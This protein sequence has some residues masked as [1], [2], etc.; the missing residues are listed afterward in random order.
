VSERN[1]F[2]EGMERTN[3]AVVAYFKVSFQY[4][5]EETE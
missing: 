2:Y 5:S 4:F 1:N 3:K